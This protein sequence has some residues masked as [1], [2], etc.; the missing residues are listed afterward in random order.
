MARVNG[1]LVAVLGYPP[2]VI[3]VADVQFGINALT[4]KIHRQGDDV[5]VAGSF[6]VAK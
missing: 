2:Q 5:N 3:N 1:Q 4:E 6:T